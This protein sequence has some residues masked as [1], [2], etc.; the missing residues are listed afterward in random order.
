MYILSKNESVILRFRDV[1]L[2]KIVILYYSMS[3]AVDLAV[4][5]VCYLKK[6]RRFEPTTFGIEFQHKNTK[7]QPSV[8]GHLVSWIWNWQVNYEFEEYF[9]FGCMLLECSP[10]SGN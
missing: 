7:L 1:I 6:K 3:E 10:L 2:M 9:G 4:S 8:Y 5:G